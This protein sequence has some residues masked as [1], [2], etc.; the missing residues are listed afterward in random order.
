METPT[1]NQVQP[2]EQVAANEEVVVT[3][4]EDDELTKSVQLTDDFVKQE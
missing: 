3:S 1:D 2:F 4:N